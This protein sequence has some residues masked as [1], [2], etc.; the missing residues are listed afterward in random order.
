MIEISRRQVLTPYIHV[1]APYSLY[2]PPDGEWALP[3]GVA[4]P[5]ILGTSTHLDQLV[6]FPCSFLVRIGVPVPSLGI[7]IWRRFCVSSFFYSSCI[8]F[9]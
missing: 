8:P 6:M 9:Q 1:Y 5:V 4:S 7:S 2:A 3:D